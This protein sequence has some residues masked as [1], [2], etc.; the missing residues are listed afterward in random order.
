[1]TAFY[2]RYGFNVRGRVRYRSTYLGDFTLYSGGLD[3]QTVLGETI[4]DAQVG[5]DFSSGALKGL[6]VYVQGQN[7]TDTRSATLGIVTNPLSYLKYQ[8]Y[9]RRFVVGATFKF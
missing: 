6:S 5:Y 4:Y 3:R 7:L 2:E 8:S 1:V 9:G